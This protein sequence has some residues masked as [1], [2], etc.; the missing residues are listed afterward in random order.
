MQNQ[1][2]LQSSSSSRTE[3]LFRGTIISI[4]FKIPVQYYSHNIDYPLTEPPIVR[5]RPGLRLLDKRYKY[6]FYFSALIFGFVHLFNFPF[7][8]TI[9][10][11]SPFA[12]KSSSTSV[13]GYLRIAGL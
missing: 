6:I 13:I 1:C 7:S 10:L 9:P 12:P 11:L 8:L 5:K 3:T 2:L 4:V